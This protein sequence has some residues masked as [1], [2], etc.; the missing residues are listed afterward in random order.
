MEISMKVE[1]LGLGNRNS[2]KQKMCKKKYESN[3]T[4]K[5]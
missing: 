4:G 2:R 5:Y 1:A 3:R